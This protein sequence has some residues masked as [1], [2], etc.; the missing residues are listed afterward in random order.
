MGILS[1]LSIDIEQLVEDGY[2]DEYI[3]KAVDTELPLIQFIINY[4]RE[5]GSFDKKPKVKTNIKK[6]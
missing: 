5:H 1:S 3:A 4:F 2:S 6:K